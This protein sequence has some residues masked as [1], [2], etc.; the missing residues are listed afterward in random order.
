M[1]RSKIWRKKWFLI[2]R[3][4]HLLWSPVVRY[5]PHKS[6]TLDFIESRRD[7]V[8]HFMT[9]CCEMYVSI[10]V[11]TTFSLPGAGFLFWFATRTFMSFLSPPYLPYTPG[12][13]SLIIFDEEHRPRGL[14][15]G[16]V[17]KLPVTSLILVRIFSSTLW[18]QKPSFMP[19]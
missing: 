16:N 12:L 7:A 5:S 11:H 3:V 10:I 19:I 13:F 6:S 17:F 2:E 9:C 15:M 8:R 4:T 18:A 1:T 14:S